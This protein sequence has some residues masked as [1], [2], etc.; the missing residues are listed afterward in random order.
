[1]SDGF[2]DDFYRDLRTELEPQLA[3]LLDRHK[4]AVARIDWSYHAFL[5]LDA[6]RAGLAEPPL[7]AT[8][9]MAI[10]MALLTEVNLPWY[11][12]GLSRGLER[13]PGPL[14]EFVYLWTSEEDQ[15]A[16]LLESYLLLT[17]NGDHGARA[18][19]RK[20]IIAGGWHHALAGPFEG[21]VYTAIQEAATRTY[22]LCVA[23][24]CDGEHPM[25]GAAL[26]RIAKDETL[27]MAF[28]RDVVKLHLDL[29][30]DY[31]GPLANVLA[32]F[33]MPWAPAALREFEER[34]NC[35]ATSGVFGLADYFREVVQPLWSYW[36]LDG[37]RPREERTREA[38]AQ[39]RRYRAALRKFAR[40]ERAP[41]GA[42][43]AADAS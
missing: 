2:V 38:H 37:L 18:R 10:E 36:G 8:A 43:A 30:P 25:L 1:M 6:F 33:E 3:A 5:P 4:E 31:L 15:H 24:A 41:V 14:R 9:Y 28:Y 16:T 29:D 13:C 22:Y 23:R 19:A 42:V 26:R 39:L 40:V 27:H 34:R 21:M 32:S 20:T 12:A 7:S 17:G 11:T 35:L